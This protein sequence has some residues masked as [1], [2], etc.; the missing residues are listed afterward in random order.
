MANYLAG[1]FGS[2]GKSEIDILVFSLLEPYLA[3]SNYEKSRQL[4]ITDTRVKTLCLNA[5]LR[6]GKKDD[7]EIIKEILSSLN[8]ENSKS[9]IDFEKGEIVFGLEN[10][11]QRDIF[12]GRIKKL[13]YYADFS[14]NSEIVRVSI[15]AIFGLIGD[16]K[17][18]NI[19]QKHKNY[20]E[21]KKKLNGE[22]TTWQKLKEFIPDKK[23]LTGIVL[24]LLGSILLPK[25]I[26]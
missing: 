24:N 25:I 13:G 3:M 8:R 11:V 10:S 18:K 21:I 5:H 6:Y 12:I 4:K 15:D 14:F 1:S 2:L 7:D 23:S 17:C 20:D 19:V 26:T 22:K 9:K 16:E